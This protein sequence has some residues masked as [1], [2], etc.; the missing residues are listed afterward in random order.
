MV[1][2]DDDG[3]LSLLGLDTGEMREKYGRNTGEIREK[4]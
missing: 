4:Y 1:N 2:I 3:N